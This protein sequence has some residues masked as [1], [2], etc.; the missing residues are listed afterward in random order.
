MAQKS[1]AAPCNADLSI[2]TACAGF[3]R[4]IAAPAVRCAVRLH[5]T[6]M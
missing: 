2:L 3:E 5:N 6:G 1:T 4:K